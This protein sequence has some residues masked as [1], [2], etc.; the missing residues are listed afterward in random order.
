MLT[1]HSTAI[2]APTQPPTIHHHD[3][4]LLRP[5]STLGKP[6]V[7]DPSVSFLRRTEYISSSSSQARPSSG[8]R[9]LNQTPVRRP[10]K[11]PSPEPDRGTPAYV[12]RKIDQ[13]FTAAEGGLADKSRVR[14]PTKRNLK[15]VDASPLLPDLESFPDSG[16]YVTIKFTNNPVPP[17]RSYDSRLLNG[18]L[19]P[20]EKSEA[21]EQ[22][23][24]LAVEAYAR[25]PENNPRPGPAMNYDFYLNDSATGTRNFQRKFDVDNPGRDE[26]RLYTHKGNDSPHFQYNRVRAYETSHETELDHS[27]KYDEEVILAFNDQDSE[28]LQKAV[29]YYPVMQ[30]SHIRPQRT[31]NI[32]R[33]IGM[34]DG[35]DE[36]VVDQLDVTVRDPEPDLKQAMESFKENPYYTGAEEADEDGEADDDHQQNGRESRHSPVSDEHEQDAEGDEE[37]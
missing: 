14:H 13:S 19:R 22:A 21:E 8:L 27:S 6:K 2:Q 20:I 31:K 4:A 16:A 3:R 9:S 23:Y 7:S 36:Q 35:E 28:A 1:S 33:T 30:R 34:T 17:S 12:K 25:D 11:R 37:E 26:D 29:Y 5:L 10:L 18:L 24:S 15:L 32:A